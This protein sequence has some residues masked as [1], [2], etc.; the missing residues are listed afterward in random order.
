MEPKARVR[1]GFVGQEQELKYG[2][3]ANGRDPDTNEPTLV[4]CL[5]CMHFG[6]QKAAGRT[7]KPISTIKEYKPPFRLDNF[8]QHNQI[9]HEEHWKTYSTL[10][11]EQKRN[12]FPSMPSR[13]QNTLA[14]MLTTK[15]KET[16]C[17][18]RENK[19]LAAS[20]GMTKT[21]VRI[22][23]TNDNEQDG[24]SIADERIAMQR[25]KNAMGLKTLKYL[26]LQC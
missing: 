17:L 1:N 3:I 8:G 10:T 19:K 24:N 26:V 5:F 11:N 20:S 21:Q 4:T 25:T 2:V 9:H 15:R 18:P 16:S 7:R 23:F 13:T 12:Y 6:R 14:T 22:N